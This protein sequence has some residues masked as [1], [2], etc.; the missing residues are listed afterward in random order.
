MSHIKENI[1]QS[2]KGKLYQTKVVSDKNIPSGKNELTNILHL[3]EI[4][5]QSNIE[6]LQNYVQKEKLSAFELKI[7]INELLKKYEPNNHNFY[8]MLDILL[9]AGFPINS[10]I[11]IPSNERTKNFNFEEN[12]EVNLL[13]LAIL[14][15]DLEF[16]RLVLKYHDTKT[17]NQKDQKGFSPIIYSI[18]NNK[19]DNTDILNMLI[20]AGADMNQTV[21][22]GTEP[23]KFQEHSPFTLACLKNLPKNIKL[24]LDN[25]KTY[26]NFGVIPT[27][28]TGLHICAREGM[29]EA[30]KVLL[31][32]EKINPDILNNKGK[33]ALELIYDNEKKNE[34]MKL[35]VNYY[36]NKSSRKNDLSGNLNIL[37][38]N[39]YDNINK[40]TNKNFVNNEKLNINNSNIINHENIYKNKNDEY[41]NYINNINN[42]NIKNKMSNMS[43]SLE[44]EQL[45]QNMNMENIG[46]NE[47]SDF[48]E[49]QETKEKI[50]SNKNNKMQKININ[51][52]NSEQTLP[53]INSMKLLNHNIYN[54]LLSNYN[55][56]HN[57]NLEI[58][59]KMINRKKGHFKSEKLKS[60]NNFFDPKINSIP[61]LNLDLNDKTFQLELEIN[62]IKNQITNIDKEKKNLEK[63]IEENHKL[64]DEKSDELSKKEDTF[65]KLN[66]DLTKSKDKE[67]ELLQKQ[68]D[69]KEEIDNIP[70]TNLFKESNKDKNKKELKFLL[71]EFEDIEMFKI[72]N[73]DLIDYQAYITEIMR[74]QNIALQIE[75]RINEIK[76]VLRSISQE[77]EIQIYGSY[78]LGLNMEWSDID[79]VLVKNENPPPE[80]NENN[81]ENILLMQQNN[82]NEVQN[83]NVSV[84]NTD[85]TRESFNQMILN[86]NNNNY[87]NQ[88][89]N[90][91]IL[92]AL[93]QRLRAFPWVKKFL[94]R[95]NLEVKILKLEC[96]VNIPGMQEN[97]R[98]DIDISIETE[99]HN[100]LKCVNLINSYLKEYSVLKPIVIALRAILHSANLHLP[101]KGGL[102]AYG[103]ILMVV[104]YIQS[105]KENFNKNEPDLCG[106][107]FYGFLKHYGII[108]DFNKYL[109]LTYPTNENNGANTDKESYINMNQYGQEFIILDPLNS[110][111]NVASKSFQFM[112]LK[113]AFMIAYMVTKEDCDCGCH[114]GE[115]EFENSYNSTEHCYLKRML[116]SVRRFQG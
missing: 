97:K 101:D 33:K 92:E 71:K 44:Q 99:K 37:K 51:N 3:N 115:A 5:K 9:Q 79:L 60:L 10:G 13:T 70:G 19:N 46:F 85:S 114:F 113:M 27:G 94:W 30:L 112:N 23:N 104:S 52:P 25:Q 6:D 78:A 26:V 75:N 73:K 8:T 41:K 81:D 32:S 67:G 17:I 106:K 108:F 39:A 109:I 58:P 82:N 102:S 76:N 42:L 11:N 100:G 7:A 40:D 96:L 116:N 49:D 105:Q 87:Q 107:I 20:T 12:D 111:N 35:F 53:Q 43:N 15:E 80:N 4:I 24:L 62:E 103:L 16:I 68:K 50:N 83:D 86:Q 59:I 2:S 66:F 72:L 56:N 77:Y 57:F 63:D 93:D 84:A 14:F 29:E 47:S 34:I 36:N 74:R 38:N 55:F 18:L 54:N 21:K 48:S 95:E 28:D 31:S 98:F 90:S 64:I 65:Q 91:N 22:L 89:N 110:T 45:R 88:I 1:D 61:I 69:I